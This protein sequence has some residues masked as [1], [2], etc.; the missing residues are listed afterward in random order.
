MVL[1]YAGSLW[2]LMVFSM[3]EYSSK[4]SLAGCT[5]SLSSSTDLLCLA[6]IW[7]QYFIWSFPNSLPH[8]KCRA[9]LKAEQ[10]IWHQQFLLTMSLRNSVSKNTVILRLFIPVCSTP[11]R[12]HSGHISS[13]YR[14]QWCLKAALP[15]TSYIPTC[16]QPGRTTFRHHLCSSL[17]NGAGE[18]RFKCWAGRRDF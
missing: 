9:L 14:S 12:S 11:R 18:V 2:C 8:Y 10:N 5:S 15:K 3:H 13:G 4:N 17:T 1:C 6:V 16:W 7:E